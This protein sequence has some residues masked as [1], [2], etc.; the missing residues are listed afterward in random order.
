MFRQDYILREIER[1]VE[2]CLRAAGLKKPDAIEDFQDFL[3]ENC[4]I[5]TGL[6]LRTLLE[7]DA[8][9]LVALLYHPGTAKLPQLVSCGAWL[10]EAADVSLLSGRRN[11]ARLLFLRGAQ[12]LGFM[13][14]QHGHE[15]EF[16][17]L[18]DHLQRLRDRLDLFG[19][20]SGERSKAEALLTPRG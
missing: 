18:H 1:M 14:A 4:E 2:F 11:E 13:A 9:K 16:A 7:T 20:G 15:D 8:Q 10:C 12:I 17:P 6:P 19:F 3:E 5:L